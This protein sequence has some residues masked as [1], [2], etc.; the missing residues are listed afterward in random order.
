[1]SLSV[2]EQILGPGAWLS[3]TWAWEGPLRGGSDGTALGWREVL[4]L[5]KLL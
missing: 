3:E 2:E 1:M 5:Y 4:A